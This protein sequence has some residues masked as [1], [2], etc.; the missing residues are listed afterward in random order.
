MVHMTRK[1]RKNRYDPNHPSEVRR[2]EI[3]D[4]QLK[5][6]YGPEL[7]AQ[8]SIMGDLK[9]LSDMHAEHGEAVG[10]VDRL[11]REQAKHLKTTM[12][13]PRYTG[14]R[15]E[16]RDAFYVTWMTSQFKEIY[17]DK[18]I[19]DRDLNPS[20]EGHCIAVEVR[21]MSDIDTDEDFD[22][23]ETGYFEDEPL[24]DES[25]DTVEDEPIEPQDQVPTITREQLT[26]MMSRPEYKYDPALQRQVTEGFQFLYGN[27]APEESNPTSGR[28]LHQ[29]PERQAETSD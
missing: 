8:K 24:D 20:S 28:T 21:K 6:M 16:G 7:E 11:S 13:D 9:N 27:E 26:E 22:P 5:A 15:A 10:E 17:P 12:L 29:M 3:Q 19:E 4:E 14:Q 1:L 18:D 23:F 2:R 25:L